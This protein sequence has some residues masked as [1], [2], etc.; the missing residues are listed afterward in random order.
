[1]AL[2]STDL[3]GRDSSL[4]RASRTRSAVRRSLH[5]V[6]RLPV[7]RPTQTGCRVLA[8]APPPPPS[9]G[10][11][12]FVAPVPWNS[13]ISF[14]SPY[15]PYIGF[16]KIPGPASQ[17]HPSSSSCSRTGRRLP[18]SRHFRFLDPCRRAVGHDRQRLERRTVLPTSSAS[19][20][21]APVC[22]ECRVKIAT[23]PRRA[24]R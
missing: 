18:Y 6:D 9:L 13:S 16:P 3:L 14:A 21:R 23:G 24:E 2:R 10:A 8:C 19:T 1:M 17:A 12:G 4:L 15:K 20:C 5:K 7:S 22:S 11:C